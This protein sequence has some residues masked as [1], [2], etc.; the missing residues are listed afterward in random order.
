[1]PVQKKNIPKKTETAENKPKTF[2]AIVVGITDRNELQVQG[3]EKTERVILA[4]I[5]VPRFNR[6]ENKE[7]MFAYE[8]SEYLRKRLIGKSV[9]F[10]ITTES[11]DGVRTA[12]PMMGAENICAALLEQGYA[13][14]RAGKVHKI[15]ELVAAEEKAKQAKKGLHSDAPE[16]LCTRKPEDAKMTKKDIDFFANKTMKGFIRKVDAPACYLGETPDRK[17]VRIQLHGV[18]QHAPFEK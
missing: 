7:E 4:H 18:H 13:V 1:M 15:D 2:S 5:D 6:K 9:K 10:E 8:C 14:L 16:K 3:K 11:Q 12:I 17:F